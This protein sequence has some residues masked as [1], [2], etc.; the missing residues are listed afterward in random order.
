[1]IAAR[2][3]ESNSMHDLAVLLPRV[4]SDADG[5]MAAD[6][7]MRKAANA[8]HVFAMKKVKAFAPIEQSV[9]CILGNKADEL[10]DLLIRI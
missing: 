1:M 2:G 10:W 7:W 4:V 3:G 5:Q 6:Y 9:G 8:K